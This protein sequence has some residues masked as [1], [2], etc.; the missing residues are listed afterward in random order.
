MRAPRPAQALHTLG[1]RARG[2]HEHLDAAA[3]EATDLADPVGDRRAIEPAPALV[4]RLDPIFTDDAAR[5]R[6]RASWASRLLEEV[7]DRVAE[8]AR[9][10]RC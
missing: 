7:H 8:R 1:D 4:S 6:E 5:F 10:L 3:R 2:D 9:C